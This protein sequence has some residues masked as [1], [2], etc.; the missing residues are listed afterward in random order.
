M[1]RIM[2]V[3]KS[4]GRSQTWLAKQ[5]EFSYAVVTNYCNNKT[6]PD[7][8][9]LRKVAKILEVDV[10]ELMTSEESSRPTG[11]NQSNRPSFPA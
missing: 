8:L 2:E 1:N 3:L 4:Q 9:A 10:K 6:Q 11:I 7:K 5:L